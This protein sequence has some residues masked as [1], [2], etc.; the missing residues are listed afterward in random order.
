MIKEKVMRETAKAF[1]GKMLSDLVSLPQSVHDV[2]A[3][4]LHSLHGGNDT[5]MMMHF[6]SVFIREELAYLFKK[7]HCVV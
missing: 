3:N 6:W 2:R 4:L 5:L 7:S 1:T